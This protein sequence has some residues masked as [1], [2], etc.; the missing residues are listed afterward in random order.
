MSTSRTTSVPHQPAGGDPSTI[1]GP[2]VVP[3][4]ASPADELGTKALETDDLSARVPFN[5]SK[6]IEYGDDAARRPPEGEVAAPDDPIAGA[7]TVQE[8]RGSDKLG[9]GGP[10]LGHNKTIGPLDRVR[11]DAT[12]RRLTTN[13]GVPVGDNQHALKAGLRGPTLLEDF[14]LREKLTHFDHERIPERIVHARGSAAHGV[15]A[16]Y[17]ALTDLTRACT[18]RRGRQGDAGVRALLDSTRGARLHR[19]RARRARLRGEVLHR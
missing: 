13:Q 6:L 5:A 12:G 4:P 11:A 18:L 10:A 19:H 2:A 14:I 17:E 7:S 1:S 3:A 8:S 15:F 9:S 16:C